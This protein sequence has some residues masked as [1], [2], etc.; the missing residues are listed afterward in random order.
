MDFGL[1]ADRIC[2]VIPRLPAP[3]PPPPPPPHLPVD[4]FRTIGCRVAADR[5]TNHRSA[6]HIFFE[7]PA[8]YKITFS[9]T[10]KTKLNL[11]QFKVNFKR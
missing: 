10:W 3:P 5:S 6:Q 1:E 11:L 2:N 8:K 9:L 4:I 7:I